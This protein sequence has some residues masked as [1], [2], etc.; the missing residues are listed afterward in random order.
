MAERAATNHG[1]N[2]D[3]GDPFAYADA[4]RSGLP[5]ERCQNPVPVAAG[6]PPAQ[7]RTSHAEVIDILLAAGYTVQPPGLPLTVC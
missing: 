4:A 3:V 5:L 1:G 6:A 2:P 7:A